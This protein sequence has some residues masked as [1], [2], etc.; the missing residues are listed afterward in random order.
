MFFYYSSV[1]VFF[2]E[3]NGAKNVSRTYKNLDTFLFTLRYNKNT[4]F[5]GVENFA[6]KVVATKLHLASSVRVFFAECNGAKN[7][8]RTYKNLDTFLFTLCYNKNTRFDGVENFAYKVVA[9]KLHLAS[10]VR[11]FF[12][13]CNGAKNV[14]RTPITIFPDNQK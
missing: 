13:E 10:S 5:D 11:V 6:Y 3:C 1:R 9:T 8:S 4:R 7:V 14:S 2:A 12:A